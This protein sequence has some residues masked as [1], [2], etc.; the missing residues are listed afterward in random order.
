M[1]TAKIQIAPEC[2]AD[3]RRLYELT[4]T[5]VADIAATMGI[6]RRTLER[7]IHEWG[8]TPRSAPRL[9]ADRA[10]TGVEPPAN[11]ES[12]PA[13]AA[14]LSA[15]ARMELAARIQNTVERGLDAVDRVLDKVGPADEGGAE[16]SARTLAAIARTLHA[17][18]A[19]AE[20]ESEATP[21][22]ETDDDPVPRDIDEF[23]RELTRRIRGFIEARRNGG[24]RL[25]DERESE[26]D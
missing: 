25:R 16:R 3:G 11:V 1:G 12:K 19:I 26:M 21:P 6:S 22:D 23:R 20:P 8:W 14:S 24:S 4:L 5:P 2:I 7:R 18:A 15:A 17:M 10:L 13:A 9:A